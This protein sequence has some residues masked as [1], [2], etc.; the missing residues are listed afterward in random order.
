MLTTPHSLL[1]FFHFAMWYIIKTDYYKERD[2]IKDLL[3]LDSIADI[4]FPNSRPNPTDIGWD[5]KKVSF[6][7]VINGI[8][9]A[10]VKDVKLLLKDLNANGYFLQKEESPNDKRPQ[11]A[12]NAHLF[13]LKG[14]TEGLKSM[15]IHAKISDEE[16]Y[17]YKVCI[18]Q[19]A[20]HTDDIKIVGKDYAELAANNDIVMITNGPF[21]GYTGVIKQVKSHGVKDRCFLF[22]LGGFCV[23]LSGIRRYEVI[24]VKETP[25]G[26][27]A[28][29]PNTWRYIDQLQGRLQATYFADN[30]A[31]VLRN[32][33]EQYN[34]VKD[35]EKCQALLL[36]EAKQKQTEAES[37]ELALQAVWLL[38]AKDDDLAAL[39]SL[40]R[41]FQSTDN[42][43]A[44]GLADLIPDTPLR[45]F[46][47]PTS[48]VE[49]P[50]GKNYT[51]L[52]HDGFVELIFRVNLKQ[53]FQK[54]EH[55]PTLPIQDTHEG[56]FTD[57]G[58][59]K[60][61]MRKARPFRLS[62]EEY[63]YYVHIGLRD[64]EDG[65]GMTAMV[66]WGEFAHRYHSLSHYERQAFLED[67]LAKGYHHTH[68][69]LSEASLHDEGP[70]L[71][72]FTCHLPD[73]KTEDLLAQYE[74]SP[75]TARLPIA[76][77]RRLLPLRHLLRTCIP[78]AVEFWQRQR[79]LEWRHLIQR[80]VL[81]HNQP[82]GSE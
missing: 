5:K 66:N 21:V 53:E 35:T 80:H 19:S 48:G 55:Y 6:R 39:K 56:R 27:K 54:A 62:P 36:E 81:L 43:V 10:Y 32:I 28:Q 30:S 73:I 82:L 11:V 9:F 45:P 15:L 58:K 13:S 31:A 78:S 67:L 77:L 16:I 44:Y 68:R 4:Y 26:T 29:L 69:L 34:K 51:L 41:Y 14:E 3:R 8:L 63:I 74:K 59:L 12:G 47:T 25:K 50:K 38:Q 23:Q 33:L 71:S 17:R 79:L 70:S 2:A 42:S 24:V 46:L 49:L 7:P 61:K 72:G 1:S 76:L 60:G 37:R 20:V 40:S 57:N 65:T 52:P 22:S 18:E 75:K 64:N